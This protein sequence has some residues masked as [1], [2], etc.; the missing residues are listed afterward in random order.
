VG[1]EKSNLEECLEKMYNWK[2]TILKDT[3]TMQLA[4]EVLNRESLGII[5]VINKGHRLIGT[6]TDGDIRRGL[7][8][9]LKMD[10][11]IAKIMFKKPIFASEKDDKGSILSKMKELDILQIPIVDGGGKVVGLET[12]QNLLEKKRYDNPVFLMAGGFGKRLQP[13]TDSIPKP[14]LKV[15][16]KPI[17]ENI[18]DQFIVAGFH[19]FYIST[20]YKADMI[21]EYFGNGSDRGITI[22]YV[23]E[24]QPLGTA[25]SL[26]LLPDNMLN[27]PILM[28]NGDLL[29]KIDFAELLHFHEQEGGDATMCVR[30]YDFQVPYG[31]IK[32]KGGRIA[33]IEEKPTHRFF[34]NAGVYV[35][36][37]TILKD[38]NGQS[39]L[40]M[41]QLLEKKIENFGQVNMFPIHEYWLDIGQI[42]QFDQAQ[43]DSISFFR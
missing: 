33:S 39:Y 17:L 10:V 27:L 1:I 24:E 15:G 20:H 7:I 16:L 18:L 6:V 4:V 40:D 38:V 32:A 11:P 41:P 12:L 31:V 2:K 42:S 23:Y 25:G 5:M 34:V 19:N 9:R 30:E 26:G 14:L 22:E 36:D 37:P 8:K 13:L 29:T 3:D 28:M 43:K 35:L 21:K